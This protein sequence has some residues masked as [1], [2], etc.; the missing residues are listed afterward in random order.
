MQ[1]RLRVPV[2]SPA[3]MP[4]EP[5]GLRWR[6][7][8]TAV[9]RGLR[10]RCPRCGVGDSMEGYLRIRQVCSHCGQSLGHIRA[11]D[12]PA[13]FTMLIA[14]HVVVPLALLAEQLWHPPLVPMMAVGGVGMAVLIWRL[15]PRVKGG[16]LAWMWV[17]G[18]D[19]AEVQGDPEHHG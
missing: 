10:R 6:R 5:P 11:D 18:L 15:L 7:M 13:Y 19:G 3:P 1:H 8:A 9:L 2:C 16:V 14:G 12:G 4:T 17:L